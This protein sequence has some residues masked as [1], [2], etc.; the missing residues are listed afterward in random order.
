MPKDF[1]ATM[2]ERAIGRQ[3]AHWRNELELSLAEASQRVGFSSAKLSMIEN[4]LQ[5][6]STYDIMALGYAYRVRSDEWQAV[7]KRTDLA[8]RLRHEE[9]LLEP[10]DASTD[11]TAAGRDALYLQSLSGYPLATVLQ[12][13]QSARAVAKPDTSPYPPEAASRHLQAHRDWTSR[14]HRNNPIVVEGI[15][16]EAALEHV[17]GGAQVMKAELLHLAQL[18]ELR[19]ITIRVMP[20]DKGAYG[21]AMSSTTLLTFAHKQHNTVVHIEDSAGGRYVEDPTAVERMTARFEQAFNS[22]L[23]ERLSR[24]LLAELAQQTLLVMNVCAHH[25]LPTAF[26]RADARPFRTV[27][28]LLSYE[29]RCPLLF[30]IS[31]DHQQRALR[32]QSR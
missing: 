16:P 21:L 22:A 14:I 6:C 24:E 1:R 7:A 2:Q 8:A 32:Q 31:G 15:I 5:P 17:V 23:S 20:A 27:A 9:P 19:H 12:C 30:P 18:S 26:C 11:F 10:F 28:S 25:A 13:D 3:L 4:A 29:P